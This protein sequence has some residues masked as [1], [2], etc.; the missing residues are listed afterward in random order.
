VF[1]IK[2]TREKGQM[3]RFASSTWSADCLADG[4]KLQ[5]GVWDC[6]SD[7]YIERYMF[8]KSVANGHFRG[9]LTFAPAVRLR[10]GIK[11]EM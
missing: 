7:T 10:A 8:R 11:A 3:T 6:P 1:Q 2:I 4:R 5:G 9:D